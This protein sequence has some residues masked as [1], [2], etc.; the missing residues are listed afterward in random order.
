MTENAAEQTGDDRIIRE[1]GIDARIALIVE[2]VLR[3]IGFRL[4]RVRLSGQNG[5]T[6]QIMAEREDGT[7]TV[8]DCEEV[9]RAVSPALDV[10]DPIDKAYHLE[11]SSPGIDRP[12]VRKSDFA[13]WIGHLVKMETSILVDD[14]KRFRGKIAEADDEGILIERDQ[15]AYGEEPTVRVPLRRDRRGAAD[16]DRRP[17]PRR[18]VAKDNRAPQGS[19]E[20]SRRDRTMPE[21]RRR[22]RTR[23]TD[24]AVPATRSGTKLG[25][26]TMVVS[27]NRL[28]LLQIADAVAREKSIDKQIVIAAMA[29]AIQKAARSRYGQETNIR[30]DINPK[31]GEMK[32][33]RLMEV[34]EKVED[35]AT[36]IALVS[37]RERNPDAQL[38]DF[39]AEQ[40]PPMDFGRI[41]A[42]SAK[43]VIVQKVRE[44][45]RDR[46]FDEYKDR[47]GEIVNGTVKRV[48][49]GNVIVDLGRGEA[50][51]RR[52]ELIPRENYKLWRPRPRLCL[53]R[54]PR[55]A[56]PADLPVA[57]PSAVHGEAVHHG[58]AGNL[59]RHHRDQV[60]RPRSG[61]AR[62]D[63]R[64]LA[65][66]LDRPGR[67]LRRYA[68]PPRPG[69]RRRAAGR[70]DRHH[71]V[72]AVGR[73]L[74][75]QRAAAGRGR[76]GRARRGCRAHRGRGARRPAVAGHRPPRPERAPRLAA[77]RLGHRHPDRAGRVRAPPEGIRRALRRCSWKRSTSTRWSARCWLPKASPASR[78]SPMSIPTRS[79]R[80][81]ASTRTPPTEIQTRAREYLDKIEA[82]HD[83]KRKALG[84]AGRAARD[85]RHHHRDAGGARRGRRQDDRGLR[86][87][88]CRRSRRLEGAQGRRDEVLP[89]RACR[90]TACRA[91]T[92]SR[93][94]WLPACKAGWITEDEV[95]RGRRLPTSPVSD[96]RP[97]RRQLLDEMNDRTCIVTR[98]SGEPDES[99]PF[100]RR[101]GFDC[102]SGPQEKT[103]RPRLLG[104]RR[105]RYM[106][107]RRRPRACSRGRFK[108]RGRRT[109]RIWALWSTPCSPN[110]RSARSDWPAR[111]A[112]VALGATKVD[113]CGT[114]RKGA[115]R[116]SCRRGA[117]RTASAR[118]PR[119]GGRPSIWADLQYPP[120]N[121]FPKRNWVWHWGH[122]CDTCC[123]SRGRRG[124][125]GRRSAWLRLT[126]IGADP[127]MIWQ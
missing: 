94:L 71:S 45:E 63:R 60:G 74:H 13:T 58:S 20:A 62:Q 33:Q 44:A 83:D 52:D 100:R 9:S 119:P 5:L 107:T 98:Q 49:Y 24:R 29:D 93:W 37:A 47:I 75:R 27:A 28:E 122:K 11:V 19:Q 31:T 69:G 4:V 108:A 124:Q 64:H 90:I 22:N 67:R 109:A 112:L 120:T 16:P 38:G 102:R 73:L 104:D 53:R 97:G 65:R 55:A 8:E 42:Q 126:G 18:A 6:L 41:A 23:K 105:P 32:L 1:S 78:K 68:R 72:V 92:P 12:L 15:A 85:P 2:P 111:P 81:T 115:A 96:V 113:S 3:A 118:S 123:R 54:A 25:R 77:D 46:Q 114:H 7:M 59:R 87:L 66:Q 26:K 79:P 70:E 95:S 88:R 14:R 106:S 61:L 116:A 35:Y 89:R 86:R 48:E 51:I 99:D 117:P 121:F 82:E 103:A 34:V 57:H 40:L 125:G 36:Q 127:R 91:P 39:I 30:A 10:E 43:Q 84:V 17:D 56:R 50:I 101:P 80:S 76:Q 21:R 110:R